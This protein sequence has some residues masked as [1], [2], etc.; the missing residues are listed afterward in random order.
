MSEDQVYDYEN[1]VV[2]QKKAAELEA[3]GFNNDI[4]SAMLL[5]QGR[6]LM[7]RIIYGICDIDGKHF[8]GNSKTYFNL[9]QREV[10]RFLSELVQEVAF[11]EYI[12]MLRELRNGF[13]VKDEV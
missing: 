3:L 6:K 11:E 13:K 5:P 10:G 7:A 8:T 12:L 9:G 1:D 2:D 4:K